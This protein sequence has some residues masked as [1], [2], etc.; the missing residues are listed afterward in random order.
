MTATATIEDQ[1]QTVTS[2]LAAQAQLLTEASATITTLTGE[3]DALTAEVAKH[4]SEADAFA[5]DKAAH[6]SSLA[7]FELAKAAFAA[8]QAAFET[9]VQTEAAK[10]VA[11]TGTRVPANVTAANTAATDPLTIAEFNAKTPHERMEYIKRGGK[12]TE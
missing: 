6:A 3:R 11:S 12:L 5:A 10:V 2:D 1:L 8:E 9:K 7:E 4:K